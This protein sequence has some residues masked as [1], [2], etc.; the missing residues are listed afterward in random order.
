MKETILQF[1]TGN[2]LRGFADCFI[3]AM[4]KQGIYD[5][6]TVIVSPTDSGAVERINAQNG[7][8]NLI[9]RGVEKGIEVCE[10][11]EIES[12]TRAINPYA[13]FDGFLSLAKNPDLHFIISNTTEAGICFDE[14]CKLTDRPAGSF[15][16]KLTQLLYER[17]NK[18]LN[19]FVI[20][21]CELI[22]DN[23]KK[24]ERCV[25]DYAHLWN[26]DEGF[27]EWVKNENT[28]CNTLVDRIVT[29]YPSDEAD[30]IFE[31]I[32]Y[33]D[34][35][36]DTAEPYHLWVIEGDFEDELPLVRAGFNVV[37]TDNVKPY[38]KM[39]VRILNGSHTSLVFPSLLC[40]VESVG[41]SIKDEQLKKYL[42]VCL[43]DYILPMLDDTD[44]VN[45]FA[46]AVLERFANPFIKHLWKSISLNSVSKYT[47][48]VLPT[49]ND[50]L[51]ENVVPLP[52]A[53]SL[54]CLIEYYKTNDV[55]DSE[56]SVEFIKNNNVADI[57]ANTE[58]WG[59]DL[60]IM[61]DAVSQ[62]IEKIHSDGIRNA[63]KWSIS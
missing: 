35:L 40:G 20:L 8:Y 53:F 56:Y 46:N 2:F 12:V 47:A 59:Q 29:G 6:K 57:L 55:T 14:G 5:G 27:I 22:D 18:G 37:W 16:A 61:L 21:A 15:P 32:G 45:S 50:Y 60:S 42:N 25:L 3:D 43:F 33:H 19:G 9:L 34:V 58:L 44:E 36:L 38:K 62:G 39:K 49:V 10:R 52:L 1:G 41:E 11:T 28:F 4:N 48:R 23:G 13:D 17:Y 30:K 63:I 54:S 31:E 7:K 51:S 24:L 26:L